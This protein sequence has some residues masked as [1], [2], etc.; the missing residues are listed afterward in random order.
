M[1]KSRCRAFYPGRFY[2]GKLT[3][4]ILLNVLL[5]KKMGR[6][7]THTAKSLGGIKYPY[8]KMSRRDL[9]CDGIW[10]VSR[11]YHTFIGQ[12]NYSMKCRSRALG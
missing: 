7:H 6:D 8:T 2:V 1:D 5:V 9:V 4:G 3:E 10:S 11:Q 12:N